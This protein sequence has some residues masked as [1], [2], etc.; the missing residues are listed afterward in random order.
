VDRRHIVVSAREATRDDPEGARC[1][2]E[3]LEPSAGRP[4][5]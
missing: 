5:S 4:E 2:V 1:D 3:L